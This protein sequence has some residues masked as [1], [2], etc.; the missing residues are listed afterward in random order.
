[1]DLS[2]ISTI[3]LI[4]ELNRRKIDDSTGVLNSEANKK[5]LKKLQENPEQPVGLILTFGY[6]KE[7]DPKTHKCSRCYE[8]K[9]HNNYS[10]Y[11]SRVDGNGYLMRS[12]ALC[13]SCTK[14]S[15]K[16]RSKILNNANNEGLIPDKPKD[17]D[18]C[19]SCS[20]EWYGNW[21][22]HHDDKNEKFIAWICGHCNMSLSEQ[23]GIFLSQ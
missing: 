9:D 3:D 23:R 19:T 5:V 21:H 13:D 17:G 18:I 8:I 12:N 22:R 16:K 15:N 4:N 7:K 10:Y 6:P 20:R 1:M 2:N 11:L 14:L